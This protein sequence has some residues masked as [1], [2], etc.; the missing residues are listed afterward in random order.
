VKYC[1]NDELLKGE[2]LLKTVPNFIRKKLESYTS[3]LQKSEKL[4]I[5]IED[6]FL[7]N[8]INTDIDDGDLNG[9]IITDIIID[10]GV[11][12]DIDGAIIEIEKVLNGE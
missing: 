1:R 11:G 2:I 4:R 5:E 9:A 12:G 3:H 7:E 8:G 10:T 6:W